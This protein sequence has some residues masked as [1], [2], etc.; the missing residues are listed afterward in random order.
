MVMGGDRY[1][2]NIET[3]VG[4]RD[5][6]TERG[7]T[8]WRNLVDTE[9]KTGNMSLL[10]APSGVHS[11]WMDYEELARMTYP[12]QREMKDRYG[13]SFPTYM[14]VDNPSLSWSGAQVLADAGFR[15]VARWGQG[16][17]SGGNNDYAHTQ[18]PAI[19][20]WVGP[21]GQHKVLFAWRSHYACRCGTAK[22]TS[23]NRKS[24][25]S[26]RSRSRKVSRRSRVATFSGP[27]LM[28]QWSS[29]STTTTR[30]HMLIT[31]C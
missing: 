26:R 2:Y 12:A 14:I 6:I 30:F 22:A 25:M 28:T 21:D 29:R 5:Y 27:I 20:W 24:K 17:R 23:R 3:M 9:I 10:G 7:E 1:H 8:A 19:F 18:V 16:W 13:L 11:H 15:Y 4:A 31:D